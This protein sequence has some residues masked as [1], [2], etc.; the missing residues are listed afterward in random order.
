MRPGSPFWPA[1]TTLHVGTRAAESDG[2]R[3]AAALDNMRIYDI[4]SRT[5]RL[6]LIPLRAPLWLVMACLLLAGIAANVAL[7]LILLPIGLLASGF[8]KA[9]FVLREKYQKPC[10]S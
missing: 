4:L 8:E 6:L 7:G 2:V 5:M 9:F 3:S 1:S 10:L